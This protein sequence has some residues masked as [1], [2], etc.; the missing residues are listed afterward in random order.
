VKTGFTGL[1]GHCFV[2]SVKRDLNLI[3]VVLGSGHAGNRKQK[4][5]DTKEIFSYGFDNFKNIE[6]LAGHTIALKEDDVLEVFEEKTVL[7][8][9][10]NNRLE[11]LIPLDYVEQSIEEKPKSFFEKFFKKS[12]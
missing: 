5:I 7:K 9:Y 10:V 11:K 2:G 4:W 6:I 8:V 12:F 3:T 1:A